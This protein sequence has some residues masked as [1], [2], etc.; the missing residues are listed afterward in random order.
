MQG[1]I[2]L[3]RKL[4]DNPLWS[5][6]NYLKLWIYCLFE[7]THKERDQLVGNQMVKLQRGE[8]VTGRF[9]LAENMNKGVKPK[10][11][12][13]E[14]TWWRHLDNLEKWGMLTIKSTNKFSVVTID[15]YDFYQSVFNKNDQQDDQQMSN[16]CPSDDQQMSTNNNVNNANNV[17]NNSRQKFKY[18]PSDMQLAELLL[19]CIIDNGEKSSKKTNLEKWANEVRLIRERDKK[20]HEQ[21]KKSIE[22]SQNHSFWKT[23]ILSP[24]NLRKHYQQM[25]LQAKEEKNQK[26]S[27]KKNPTREELDLS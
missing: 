14:K 21:I 8:F 26:P 17:N 5:D 20:T 19:N 1:F 23:V 6:P 9:V 15:K 7:A 2:S 11:R 4:M 22:W 3:H 24:S 12:L 10:Q 18:E 13:N 25:S 27:Q 16:S